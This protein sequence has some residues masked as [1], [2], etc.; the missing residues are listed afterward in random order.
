MSKIHYVSINGR[1]YDMAGAQANASGEAWRDLIGYNGMNPFRLNGGIELLATIGDEKD[2]LNALSGPA[3]GELVE[4]I[5]SLAYL[6][7]RDAG[8]RSPEDPSR[9]ITPAEAF[10]VTP[11]FATLQGFMQV[12]AKIQADR[13]AAEGSTG[14][15]RQIRTVG[16]P[17]GNRAQRRVAA[18]KSKSSSSTSTG[19]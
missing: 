10:A 17:D 2:G 1:D 14:P 12:G 5:C 8:D 7:M 19:I 9:P 18:K 16:D 11:L 13:E 4:V 3:G 6:A 15:T